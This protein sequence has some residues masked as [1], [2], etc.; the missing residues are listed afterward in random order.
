MNVV[1]PDDPI[2]EVKEAEERVPPEETNEFEGIAW[3]DVSG[4]ELGANNMMEA[5]KLETAYCKKVEVYDKVPLS[6][7]WE[8]TGRAPLQARWIGVDKGSRYRSRWVAKQFKNS[9][10]EEV[11]RGHAAGP[12]TLSSPLQTPPDARNGCLP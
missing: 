11:V 7:C 10:T 2:K 4:K 5:R 12:P 1:K 3:D 8:K 9:D 6:E